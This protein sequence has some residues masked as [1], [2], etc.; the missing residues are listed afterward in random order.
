MLLS[1]PDVCLSH[2]GH[3]RETYRAVPCWRN[4]DNPS[5][6]LALAE[7]SNS[8]VRLASGSGFNSEV[9]TLDS[10]FKFETCYQILTIIYVRTTVPLYFLPC[11]N[12]ISGCV[13]RPDFR[14]M[15]VL[16]WAQ[17]KHFLRRS[18]VM[19]GRIT[20]SAN[21]HCVN[22]KACFACF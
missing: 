15:D 4:G 14:Q 1:S 12:C 22:S 18:A 10:F 6:S 16:T 2:R 3:N 9:W 17:T 7:D 19:V 21:F 11:E 8:T 5:I 13:A 20:R